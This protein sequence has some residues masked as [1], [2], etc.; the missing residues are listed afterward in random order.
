MNNIIGFAG[1]MRS[2][3]G[4]AADCLSDHYGYTY[5][6]VADRL[7]K[8]CVELIGLDSVDDLNRLKNDTTGNPH[9]ITLNFDDNL[10]QKVSD[11]TDVPLDFIKEKLYGKTIVNVR[12][13]LQTLGT[14]VLRAYDE[15]WHVQHLLDDI[16]RLIK[17]G[18]K[19]VIA[20][21]RFPNEKLAIEGIGG[22]VYYVERENNPINNLHV[23]EN[24]LSES[25]FDFKHILFNVNEGN[26]GLFLYHVVEELG[27]R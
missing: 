22:E 13:L 11:L 4:I 15:F 9:Q 23:S 27:L 6:E 17:E 12:V 20:D 24:S 16:I 7:K 18:K 1:K 21:I 10:C 25:D 3:K 5:L 19:I 26:P 8:I 14:D 2:G